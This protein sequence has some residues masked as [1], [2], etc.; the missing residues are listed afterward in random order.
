MFLAVDKMRVR[1]EEIE[2]SV[3]LESLYQNYSKEVPS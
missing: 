2:E 1:Q 3:E